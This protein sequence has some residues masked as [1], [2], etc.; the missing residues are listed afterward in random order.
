[1]AEGS[2]KNTVLRWTFDILVIMIGAAVYSLG[3]HCFI[4]PNNIA[5]GGVT[6]IAI[7][8]SGLTEMQVGTLILLLNVPLIVLGFFLLN[9]ATMV[10]TLI[11]VAAITAAT[12]LAEMF[13]PVY[14]AENGNGIMAAI[15]G[16]ALM[17]AGMGLTYQREGTSGG[18]DIITKMINRFFPDLKLGGIQAA[19]DGL[20]VLAGLVVYKDINVVLFAVVAI[21]VQSKFIDVLV[22]GSQES[23]FLL[24][25]S[26]C[27][28]EIAKK[29]LEQERGVTLLNGEGA[30]SGEHRQV[31]AT[32]VHRSAYSKV[33]RIVREIDPKAF[34]VTTTAG[35]VFG[36]GFAK[37]N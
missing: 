16:G 29:L 26:R 36:E 25:F 12:D 5:P 24:I 21:F 3:V 7:I 15:F 1:M 17:G 13:V 23:R 31:V 34:V 32:A 11:S 28:T 6:G 35:E 33:K 19:L 4:S 10:K 20:V 30:Y 2:K 14:S 9:K 27:P 37:L 18:T 22:Y 8:V